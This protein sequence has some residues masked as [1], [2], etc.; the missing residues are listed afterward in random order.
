MSEE[1][2]S[3]RFGLIRHAE[4]LWNQQSRIQGHRDSPLTD[5]GKKDADEWGRQLKRIS[6]DRIFGSDLGRAAETIVHR[7]P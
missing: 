6:W 5:R 1:A 3:N 4:T 7:A 2:A